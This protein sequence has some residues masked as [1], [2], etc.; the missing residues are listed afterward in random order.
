MVR[1]S[2][3]E[4]R[5]NAEIGLST[6]LSTLAAA[7][8]PVLGQAQSPEQSGAPDFTRLTGLIHVHMVETHIGD[9]LVRQ[10]VRSCAQP[11]YGTSLDIFMT[12]VNGG[13]VFRLS[14]LGL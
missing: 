5:R 2:D 6:E 3:F 12:A 10:T 8:Q 1:R 4:M 11:G 14:S 7:R 9:S 13:T